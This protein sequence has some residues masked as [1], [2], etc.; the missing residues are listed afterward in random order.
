MK[1]L[2]LLLT[3][4]F[5]ILAEV[6]IFISGQSLGGSFTSITKRTPKP[7]YSVQLVYTGSPAGTLELQASNDCINYDTVPSGSVVLTGAA[8]STL[9]N[10]ANFYY[11]CIQIKYTRTSGTGTLAAHFSRPE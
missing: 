2:F 6:D 4:S 10:V 1:L 7:G 8:G 3:I 11:E 5:P 9:F